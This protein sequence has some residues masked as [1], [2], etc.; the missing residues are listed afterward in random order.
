M[1]NQKKRKK[2]AFTCLLFCKFAVC[3]F[4]RGRIERGFVPQRL[5]NKN[6][7]AM[8]QK[9][10]IA[11]RLLSFGIIVATTA[12]FAV[13][14]AQ[15]NMTFSQTKCLAKGEKPCKSSLLPK[16]YEIKDLKELND[17]LYF[18]GKHSLSAEG[19]CCGFVGFV[20]IKDL[21]LQNEAKCNCTDL[22]PMT[23]AEKLFIYN[24]N[25]NSKVLVA[26]GT[27]DYAQVIYAPKADESLVSQTKGPVLPIPEGETIIAYRDMGEN[28][29]KTPLQNTEE[30]YIEEKSKA[31]DC[32]AKISFGTSNSC[33]AKI[34]RANEPKET[35]NIVEVR[36]MQ[37]YMCVVAKRT[38]YRTQ[39]TPPDE[40]IIYRIDK[41]DFSKQQSAFRPRRTSRANPLNISFNEDMN[42]IYFED[43]LIELSNDELFDYA[44]K[45]KGL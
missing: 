32:L 26:S 25:S 1:A 30:I 27:V 31:Y 36:Q 17:T 13:L 28:P 37:D 45:L 43:E 11:V 4:E 38:D 18:C 35:E 19:E 5:T 6:I 22:K 42:T 10:K 15:T 40:Y 44:S 12:S 39:A 3:M 8:N 20:P 21:S 29:L 2:I 16:E 23:N 7:K 24:D 34:F 9:S 41:N 33:N 14:K